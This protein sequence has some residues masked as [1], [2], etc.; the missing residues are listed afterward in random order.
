MRLSPLDP[1]SSCAELVEALDRIPSR[2]A[3]QAWIDRW[4][5]LDAELGFGHAALLESCLLDHIRVGGRSGFRAAWVVALLSVSQRMVTSDVESALLSVL[6]VVEDPSIQRE[7]IRALLSRPLS[8]DAMEVLTAWAVEVVHLPDRPAAEHHQ[9]LAVLSRLILR[10]C[11]SL[12]SR[13]RSEVNE[14]LSVLLRS[15]RR[16][17]KKKAAQ[18]K[19]QLSEIG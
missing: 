13:Y 19:A 6:D 9:A 5:S 3:V 15:P 18:L 11:S 1:L 12:L 10:P 4:P 17:H 7:A 8:E 14:A 16:H 2:D